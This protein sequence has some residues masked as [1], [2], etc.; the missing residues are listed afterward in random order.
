M[1][2]VLELQGTFVQHY[3]RN[4]VVS[5]I[6]EFGIPAD[7]SQHEGAIVCSFASDH[8]KLSA[9]IEA[10]GDRL[11]ASWHL[12]GSR[13]YETEAVPTALPTLE[14]EYPLALGLCPACQ[15][16]M[17]DPASRRY[18]YPF[19]SC[20]H[21]GGQY[22]FFESFPFARENSSM[23]FFV[24]CEV[25]AAESK[26]VGRREQQHFISCHQCGVPVR[27]MSKTSERYANDA[28][29]FRTM[30]EVAAKAI[31]DNKRVLV[32]TTMG[33]RLFYKTPYHHSLSTLLLIDAAKIT[34]SLSLIDDEY[35]AL[36]SIERPLLHAAVRDEALQKR[37][38]RTA[39]VKYP[40][41]GFTMLLA[42]ELQRLGMAYVSYE[43]ASETTDADLRMDY[44]V[45]IKAQSDMKL[46][47]NKDIRLIASGE[48]VCFP[49]RMRP[50]R[51]LLA[52]ANGLAG[53]PDN[54]TMLFDRPE[55]FESVTVH[56]SVVLEGETEQWHSSQRSVALDIASFMSVIAE[57][58]LFGQ[59]CVGA[60]FEQEPSFLYYDGKKVIRVVPP[61]AFEPQGLLEKIA[62]L[63]EGSD[64]LVANLEVKR[65]ELFKRLEAF[66]SRENATLFEAVSMVLGLEE[67]GFD[68]VNCEALKFVGKGGM[69]VDTHVKDNRF[70][71]TAFLA[72]IISYRLADVDTVLLAYSIYESLGDY[73]SDLLQ[74]IKGKTK[75]EHIVLCG[76]HFAQQSLFSR[77]QRNLKTPAP[78]MNVRYP[79][80]RENAVVGCVYL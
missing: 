43:P 27:L 3:I 30:F 22:A 75:S 69:Q 15:K 78:K 80:G 11:P 21:C 52:M 29:S 58:D 23:R 77:L 17:F 36:L 18:Y 56:G 20:S 4:Y 40:D 25:C 42:K 59:K 67:Q 51:S 38:G 65:P 12:T 24:P 66:Q 35:H 60:H 50:V 70:D 34:D 49:S 1:A 48:R 54:D 76:S 68:A 7:V 44:D 16:E 73:F 61:K 79:I 37:V 10:I 53:I 64:R 33:Y 41:D 72:S 28:G 57:H 14:V 45:S 8:P 46:F 63:R 5:I 2:F 26:A 55:H 47:I 62:T 39:D 6:R 13:H 19:T 32:K 31:D 71:H 9:C 74:Q